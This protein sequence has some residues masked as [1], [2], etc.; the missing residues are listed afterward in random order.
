MNIATPSTVATSAS[1]IHETADAYDR[2]LFC[3]GRFSI[4]VFRGNDQWIVQTREPFGGTHER[5]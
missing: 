2:V 3:T 1:V 5:P 4:I